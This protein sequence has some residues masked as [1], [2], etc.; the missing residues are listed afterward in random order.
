MSKY[1]PLTPILVGCTNLT[2]EMKS[3]IL[4]GLSSM[5]IQDAT[6]GFLQ[7]DF[8]LSFAEYDIIVDSSEFIVMYLL[9]DNAV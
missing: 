1:R 4:R 5:V 2:K 7:T 9:E 3:S 6:A 8:V